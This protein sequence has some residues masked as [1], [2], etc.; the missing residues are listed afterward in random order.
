LLVVYHVDNDIM[1]NRRTNSHALYSSIVSSPYGLSV[2]CH[3]KAI[4]ESTHGQLWRT[5]DGYVTF[6]YA[7]GALDI[8][9]WAHVNKQ[10]WKRWFLR[11]WFFM[12]FQKT[13]KKISK[14]RIFL[15]FMVF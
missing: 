5:Y 7:T 8:V 15:V 14:G 6:L 10:G 13:K 11:F 4:T 9:N 12:V 1:T 3:G 2:C